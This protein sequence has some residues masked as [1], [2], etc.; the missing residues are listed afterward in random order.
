MVSLLTPPALA[1]ES[2]SPLTGKIFG[3]DGK[4]PLQGVTVRAYHLASEQIFT[5]APT[6]GSG[7][8]ELAQL[9]PG[10]YDLAVET[11]DGLFVGDQ[12]V[13]VGT[14]GRAVF[15]MTVAEPNAEDAPHSF[16]GTDETPA[17]VASV[18]QHKSRTGGFWNSPGGVSLIAG[19]GALGLLAIGGG[20]GDSSP[21]SP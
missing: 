17:G 2:G 19:A 3:P 8:Y 12:V 16:P 14:T 21:S 11:A 18:R 15:S 7:Q 5:S 9:P 4:T 1:A 10:Y 20:D 6:N 13:N